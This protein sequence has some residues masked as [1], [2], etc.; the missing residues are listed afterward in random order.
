MNYQHNETSRISIIVPTL[1]EAENIKASITSTQSGKDIEVIVVDGGSQDNTVLI[2]QELGIKT[3][4]SSPGRAYQMN[5]GALSASGDILLFLHADTIL[6]LLFDD[7]I[8]DAL[9]QTGVIA[10]A[11]NLTIN[12]SRW[13][14]RL[15]EW[16]VMI[17]SHLFQLPYGD[18][19]IFL[20]RKVFEQ[21]GGFSELPIM[22]D[23]DIIQRLRRI[24]R[25]AI[26][27]TAV[28]T[29]PR[30]WL[31]QG[32]LT[33]TLV[34]QIAIIAYFVGVSPARI[35]DWYCGKKKT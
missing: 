11:F 8:R 12:A 10:G 6:P 17:R 32:V 19:A 30:R 16:G 33:T 20:N 24:G 9:Q 14:L 26:V 25:I 4:F 23:F 13:S 5:A 29:S 3:I 1:N 7:M 27:P 31:Q 2:T 21:V 34:N 15:V 22:E 35:R 28:L 18:Q